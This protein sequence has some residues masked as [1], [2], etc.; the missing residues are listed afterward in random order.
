[1]RASLAQ[2][3]R[4]A[5]DAPGRA[6][7]FER[8]G[9]AVTSLVLLFGL[10]L[11][12]LEQTTT[13]STFAA[14]VQSGALVNLSSIR[15]E[16]ALMPRLTMFPE[17][18]EKAVV[19][20]AVLRRVHGAAGPQPM[21]HVGALASV[22]L[23]A[24]Q[25]RS[26]PRLV[27]LNSRLQARSD[28]SEIAVFNGADI[29][30]L[31]DGFVVR[32]P[33]AFQRQITIAIAVFMLAFWAAHLVRWYIRR[34]RRSTA[35]AGCASADRSG[36]GGDARAAR[37]AARYRRHGH[38]RRRHRRRLCD[39]DRPRVCRFRRPASASRGPCAAHRCGR[40]RDRAHHVWQRP[41]RQ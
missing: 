34:R 4:V 38:R 25:V 13:F 6:A 15:D 27:I 5:G 36:H 16:S 28:A 40:T 21:T 35:A 33:D 7:R 30:A 23:P 31:K 18:T 3:R 39:L 19:A 9:L 37:S 24:S 26:D 2:D 22:A 29:A 1:M 41:N 10:W 8:L 32:T 12:Y 11:T 20:A 17:R 14:E